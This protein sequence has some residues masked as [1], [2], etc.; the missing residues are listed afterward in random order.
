VDALSACATSDPA[1]EARYQARMTLRYVGSPAP[2]DSPGGAYLFKV[3]LKGDRSGVT[4]TIALRPEQ[5]LEELGVLVSFS[6]S[7]TAWA[8]KLAV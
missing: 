8:L 7:R 1:F 3:R 5:T 2:L 6:N 4:R